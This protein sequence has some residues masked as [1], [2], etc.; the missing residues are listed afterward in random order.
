MVVTGTLTGSGALSIP[1]GVTLVTL[2]GRGGNGGNN[3]TYQ[4][5]VPP[6]Y[7]N[8]YTAVNS[9]TGTKADSSVDTWDSAVITTPVIGATPS[10]Y[11]VDSGSGPHGAYTW[12]TIEMVYSSE[13]VMTDP[14][15]AESSSGGPY[16]GTSTTSTLNGVTR[17]WVGGYDTG[18]VGATSSQTLASTG[19]GQSMTYSVPGTGALSY[20]YE[21]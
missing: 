17:T 19:A 7:A 4:P 1:Q 12:W 21:I 8:A 3:Y 11:M 18:G 16:T 5:Y 15:E 20:S 10:N 9:Y 14:G 6:T 2:T 13:S